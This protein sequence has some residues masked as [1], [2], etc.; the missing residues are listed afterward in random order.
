MFRYSD[1]Y[2]MRAEAN[3]RKNNAGAALTAVNALRAVRGASTLAGPLTADILL[4]E[5]GRE[6][7]WEGVRRM[8]LVR[9]EKFTVTHDDKTVAD[10]NR[11][12][13]C[14]PQLALDSNPNLKQNAGYTGN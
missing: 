9:F 3:F 7:Y 2:L 1:A 14:I 10:P 5:R 12:L 11:V 4:D 8:D 6:L 13:Y